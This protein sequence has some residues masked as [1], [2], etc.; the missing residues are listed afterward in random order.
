MGGTRT[1]GTG[2]Y[3]NICDGGNTNSIEVS[4]FRATGGCFTHICAKEFWTTSALRSRAQHIRITA[5]PPGDIRLEAHEATECVATA[6]GEF[7][8]WRWYRKWF[9]R[10]WF[11][12]SW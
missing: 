7:C 12:R 10:K 6:R 5:G 9:K 2:K 11:K 3:S 1:S 8:T 4:D